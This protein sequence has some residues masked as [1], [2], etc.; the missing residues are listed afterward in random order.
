MKA[1]F[2]LLF[3]GFVKGIETYEIEIA[4]LLFGLL[5]FNGPLLADLSFSSQVEHLVGLGIL[6][7]FFGCHT[8]LLG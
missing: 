1:L 4:K 6:V 7:S 3:R 5:M 8:V 2:Y